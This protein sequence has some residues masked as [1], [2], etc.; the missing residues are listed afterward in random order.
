MKSAT[1]YEFQ[2]AQPARSPKP[3][4][5]LYQDDFAARMV[6]LEMDIDLTNFA[7]STLQNLM[8]FYSQAVDHYVQAQSGNYIFFKNKIKTLLLK[9][10]VVELIN[11][12]EAI[13]RAERDEKVQNRKA[14]DQDYLKHDTPAPVGP[15][16]RSLAQRSNHEFHY[17]MDN[18]QLNKDLSTAH[19]NK[20][21]QNLV[22]NYASHHG[23]KEEVITSSLM[24]QKNNLRVRIEERRMSSKLGNSDKSLISFEKKSSDQVK[25]R[26]QQRFGL[27]RVDQQ[28]DSKSPPENSLLSTVEFSSY[29]QSEPSHTEDQAPILSDVK[30]Y[31]IEEDLSCDGSL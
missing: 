30:P 3:K 6:E 31:E 10:R 12:Q 28:S 14:E 18:F 9:P 17:K 8:E 15:D 26:A 11:S 21:I 4:C 5:I 2:K 29:N 20:T 7:V 22:K 25:A 16:P 1:S 23:L 19:Q 24:D 13:K 27:R